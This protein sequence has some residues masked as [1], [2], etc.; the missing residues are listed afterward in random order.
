MTLDASPLF[1][2]FRLGDLELKN[3]MVMA[4]LTR[5]R[6][7]HGTDAPNDL[8]LR[9]YTQ[10]AG[11]GLI[12]TEGSQISREGQGYVWTAGVYSRE[13]VEGWKK[14]TASVHA[15]GGRIFIQLWHVGRIS[16]ISLQP[17]GGAPVAPSAIPA[18]S[19]TFIESGFAETSA[20]RAL[21][22]DEIAR[23]VADF[24]QAARNALEAGFDGVEVHGANGYLVDQFLRDGS[25]QRTDL[26]G[27][28]IENRVRFPLEVVDAIAKIWP[29]HRIGI[30]IAPV[31]P[32]N[33][34]SDANPQGLFGHLAAELGKRRIGYLH[35]V[36]GAT[37]GDRNILPF[38]YL[39]LR[40]AFGG[41]YVA[42]NGYTREMAVDALRGGR[43][44]LVAFGKLFLANPDLPERFRAD[45]PLN[46]F[47]AKTFYGGGAKGYT[48][49]PTMAEEG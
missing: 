43:A 16:H 12:V 30:R 44:D 23:V 22:A 9:Y 39:A 14:V 35:V 5:N 4:P 46:A 33:D 37:G 49:Y 27:G 48:D 11:A 45:A 29:S 38:D 6:A 13:Q 24:A 34:I 26:Y 42:N 25:N 40:R 32:A 36:E 28:S 15:A 17:E 8:S 47:D 7:T 19:R 20:P 21:G 10:R 2:P 41:A 18:K 3:R 1:A 31:S